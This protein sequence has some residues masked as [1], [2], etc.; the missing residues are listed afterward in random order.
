MQLHG[1]QSK[2]SSIKRDFA[3]GVL[4]EFIDRRYIQSC[5]YFRPS[6]VSS[7]TFSLVQLPPSPAMQAVCGWGWGWGVLSPVGDNI[8]K[9]FNTLYL[10]RFRTYKFSRQPKQ[11]LGGKRTCRKVLLQVIFLD[12]LILL[13]CL[14]S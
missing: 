14:Y 7:L 11:N 5:W 4:L 12:D 9:E 10:T 1:Y 3:A 8:L 13:W 6:F 2:M